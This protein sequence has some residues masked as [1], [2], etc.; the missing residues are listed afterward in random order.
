M[1]NNKINNIKSLVEIDKNEVL[2]YLQYKNQDI[3]SDLLDIIDQ[4]IEE[5]KKIINPRFM[6]RKYS[7]KKKKLFDKK[8]QVILEGTNLI[9]ESNDV[10]DL[11]LEC[12]ECILIVATLGL[13]IEKEIRKLTYTN[14]TKVSLL[15]LVQQLQ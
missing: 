6:M 12:D 7:I 10:Y 3:K 5:T 1:D 13:E 8:S 4:S 11:L 14:L 9:L 15:I 2:R